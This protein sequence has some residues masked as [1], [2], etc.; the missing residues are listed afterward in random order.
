MEYCIAQDKV[1]VFYL[2]LAA[3]SSFSGNRELLTRSPKSVSLSASTQSLSFTLPP[4]T[5]TPSQF[6]RSFTVSRPTDSNVI[7]VK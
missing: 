2:T 3:A 7:D 5:Q 4:E 6:Q 1:G